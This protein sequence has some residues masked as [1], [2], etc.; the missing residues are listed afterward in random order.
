MPKFEH[1]GFSFAER[2]K[3]HCRTLYAKFSEMFLEESD[4]S[5]I[6]N[7]DKDPWVIN[8]LNEEP[9]WPKCSSELIDPSKDVLPS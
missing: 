5:E 2:E 6:M 4:V 8:P 1:L 3:L 7:V 9:I